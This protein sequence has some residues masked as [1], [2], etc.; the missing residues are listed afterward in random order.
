MRTMIKSSM[1]EDHEA[2]IS[3]LLTRAVGLRMLN[4]INFNTSLILH[5][6]LGC[7]PLI[8]LFIA[9]FISNKSM[10]QI[11]CLLIQTRLQA[12]KEPYENWNSSPPW[13]RS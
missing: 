9:V 3:P 1:D 13:S 10:S 7:R 12:E 5:P 11:A 8:I 2:I 4:A 6:P